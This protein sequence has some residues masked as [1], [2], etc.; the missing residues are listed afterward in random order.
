MKK[1]FLLAAGALAV[2]CGQ[3]QGKIAYPVTAKVDTV[4]VY[5]GTE[6]ADPYRWLENDTSEAT[7]EWVKAQNEVTNRYLSQIPFR[8][9]LYD[10]L[11]RVADYER[12]GTPFKEHGRYYF[13][14]NDGLQN[15][16]VLYVQDA[17]DGEP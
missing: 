14:K 5:F 15:Q 6:V 12:M 10:R 3:Q 9:K 13:F 1:V 11:K 17:L 8:Q 2:S 4:D 7:T 16:S